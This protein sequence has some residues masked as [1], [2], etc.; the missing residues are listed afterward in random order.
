MTRASA[1][2]LRAGPGGPLRGTLGVPGDKSITHRALICAALAAGESAIGGALDAADTR[3]TAAALAALG[4][5][6]A[7][8]A[9]RVRVRGTGG[10]LRAPAAAL[11]LG[12]SGTG[13]RL[14][15]GA[16]AGRGVAATLTG[17]AS[18]RRRPMER[19]VQPL[20]AMGAA[21]TSAGGRAP[22]TLGAGAR[23][24]GIRY[25]LPVASA[26]VKSAVLLA[27]LAAEGATTVEDPYATRD[28]TE[29]LLPEFGARVTRAAGAVTLEP[30]GLGAAAV[31]VP[32]DFSSAAFLIAAALLAPGS[33]L[34]V[35]GVG[36]NDTRTG[37]LRVLA[38]MGARI[39]V[40]ARP[41]AGAEPV[42]DLRVRAG[43]L[44]A[45]TV[46]AAE[47]PALIDELPVLMAL[48]AVAEGATVIEGAGEL[49]HKESDRIEAMR[50]GLAA[51][52]APLEVAGE[53]VT[54]GGGGLRR[55]GEVASGGDH[56]I[57]MA[58][59]VAALAAPA[60]VEVRDAAWTDTSFPGFAEALAGAGAAL[61]RA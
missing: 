43:P 13:L 15:A 56:R 10:R 51:L 30:G 61:A 16:L 21:I 59:A 48:A 6:I 11:D 31:A 23:L 44:A 49:R 38:R 25:R 46:A 54:V 14:L 37:L 53:R 52:G 26:Q 55:G 40:A 36:V 20:A 5:D 2:A 60:P 19:I 33:D 28:H 17:D 45:T 50:A 58:L 57:A 27:G 22:L 29:R 41:A 1:P 35:T 4:A 3:A 39:D 12:N 24:R 7:W 18:L 42:A 9:T 34:T 8:D 32:G 47:V